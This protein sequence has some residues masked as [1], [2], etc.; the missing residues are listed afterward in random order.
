MLGVFIVGCGGATGKPLH[1]FPSRAELAKL[2]AEPE[3]QRP[4]A[5]DQ[6]EL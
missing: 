3:A 2:G 4:L 6:A 5:L 1:A